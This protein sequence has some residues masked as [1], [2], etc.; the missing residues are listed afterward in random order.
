[1]AIVDAPQ[2]KSLAMNIDKNSSCGQV[3][4]QVEASQKPSSPPKPSPT[5]EV[6]KRD[7]VSNIARILNSPILELPPPPLQV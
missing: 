1:M 6:M 4:Q 7:F 5:I 3:L 2:S